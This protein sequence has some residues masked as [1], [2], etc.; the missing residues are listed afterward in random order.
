MPQHLKDLVVILVL[1]TAVFAF[2]RASACATASTTDDFD[3]RRNLWFTITLVVFLAHNFWVYIIVS[4]AL[5]LYMLPREQ[6]KLALFFALILAVPPFGASITG[7]GIINQFFIIDYYRLLSLTLL[8]PA[9]LILRSQPNTERFGRLLPDKLLVA[10]LFLQFV[11]MFSITTVT[12]TLRNG[13]FYAFLD[14][15]LPYYVA[16]RTPRNLSTFRDA[17]MAFSIAAMVV[18]LIAAFEYSRH[19]LLYASLDRA[20]GLPS[21]FAR[22]LERADTLRALVTAGQPIPLGYA[23]AVAAGL[24]LFLKKSVPNQILWGFGFVLLLVGMIASMSRGPW[25]GALAI[26]A[27]FLATGPSPAKDL[28]LFTVLGAVA[29]ALS[30]ATPFGDSIISHLPFIGTIDTQNIDYRQRLFEISIGVIMQNPFFGA[31]DY[32]YSPAM[33]ELRQNSAGFIDLV[34]TYLGVGLSSGLTGLSLFLGY[35]IVVLS[36]IG[37]SMRRLPNRTSEEYLLGRVLFSTLVGIM[38]I[39]FTVSSITIIPVIYWSVAGL[40]VAYARMLA[41]A[42][43]PVTEQEARKVNR[44]RPASAIVR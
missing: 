18:G 27:I 9:Y 32:I 30:L 33:Q 35:F 14:V 23:M 39:I 40:G 38:I 29:G 4:A 13:A 2:A 34:N 26:F 41:S 19:W 3:R 16:S 10:Y 20:L 11:L 5:L 31:Y 7:L 42:Q 37:R 8:F 44:F 43:V 21:M 25:L 28:L 12:D 22:Y 24:F 6:N 1:A 15:F 17:L 36:G